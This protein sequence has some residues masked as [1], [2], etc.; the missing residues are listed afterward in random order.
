VGQ[1]SNNDLGKLQNAA[2]E[3]ALVFND[4]LEMLFAKMKALNKTLGKELEEK[5]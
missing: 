5:K 2:E 4:Q 1:L 3:D